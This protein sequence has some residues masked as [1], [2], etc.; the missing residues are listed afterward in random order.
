MADFHSCGGPQGPPLQDDISRC[1][2]VTD[3]SDSTCHE[4][5]RARTG[6]SCAARRGWHKT[7]QHEIR[8][9]GA[10]VAYISSGA[11]MPSS[12]SPFFKVV[13]VAATSVRRAVRVG[14][15]EISTGQA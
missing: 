7:G 9:S 8:G 14:S 10:D 6:G 2:V 12:A 11:S 13:R 4:A 15:A 1:P 3:Q 5:I